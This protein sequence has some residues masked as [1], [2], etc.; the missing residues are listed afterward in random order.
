VTPTASHVIKTDKIIDVDVL[1]RGEE[2]VRWSQMA[3][4]TPRR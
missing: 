4:C 1:A 2:G 3:H